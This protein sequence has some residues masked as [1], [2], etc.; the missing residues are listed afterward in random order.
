[1]EDS[2][3]SVR[4]EESTETSCYFVLRTRSCFNPRSWLYRLSG[5]GSAPQE[6]AQELL[7]LR[8]QADPSFSPPALYPHS[9]R[10]LWAARRS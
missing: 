3:A 2:S 6:H 1:V 7:K 4:G 5:H 9:P 10:A 8:R